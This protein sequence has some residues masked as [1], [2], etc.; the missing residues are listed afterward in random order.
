MRLLN[1]NKG[2]IKNADENPCLEEEIKI[3]EKGLKFLQ[4]F[5]AEFDRFLA[6]AMDQAR[7]YSRNCDHFDGKRCLFWNWKFRPDYLIDKCGLKGEKIEDRW[8]LEVT[9]ELCLICKGFLRIFLEEHGV[10]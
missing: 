6:M 10:I 2:K 5:S 7:Y 3:F 9:P 4:A 8:L 1:K